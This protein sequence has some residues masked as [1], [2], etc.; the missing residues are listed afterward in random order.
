[1]LCKNCQDLDI[2]RN[3]FE[4]LYGKKVVE[5]CMQRLELLIVHHQQARPAH[6]KTWDQNDVMLITYGDMVRR[7]NQPPLRSLHEFLC[8]SMTDAI[9]A[10]HI[11]P[12]FPFSSDDGFS[13]IDYREVNPELGDWDDIKDLAKDFNLMF[14]LVLNHVSRSSEWF[15]EYVNGVLPF[16]SYFIE[17]DPD[18]D[19]SCVARPRNLPLL[20]P[21][22][23]REGLRY[24]WTTFSSDQIDLDFSNPDVLFDF[25][26]IMLHYAERGARFIRL[27]AIAYLW[28][29]IGTPCIH[30]PQTHEVVK[31]MRNIMDLVGNN[32]V[33]LTETNVPHNENIS[34]FG[35][36]DEAHMVYQFT[37]PP[38]LLNT[39]VTG[40]AEK[41]TDWAA[42]LQPPPHGCTF[43]NF[44]A[45]HDGI[46]VRPLE[47]ILEPSEIANLANIVQNR[48]GH[49]S[50]KTN[51]D[52]TESPYELNITY[53]SA[54]ADPDAHDRELDIARFICSQ[55]IPLE[56]RGIPGVYFNNL[57]AAI[58]D[59]KAVAER[60]TP[61]A[62]NRQKWPRE[63]LDA[64]ASDEH[65]IHGQVFRTYIDLLEERRKHPA[66]HPE[67]TQTI[68]EVNPRLFAVLRT[69]QNPPQT[70]LAL[71]NVTDHPLHIPR[72]ILSDALPAQPLFDLLAH[73]PIQDSSTIE[74]KPYQCRWLTPK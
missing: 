29:E 25:M 42:N 8:E 40:N 49:V 34:Y 4:R 48:G 21:T 71:N 16:K 31:L 68:L 27:D 63:Q 74:L 43:F 35:H 67:A 66:F 46:G 6:A 41:L 20:T 62:I 28:K 10:V 22:R 65:S 55:T 72:S 32:L 53:F 9:N 18:A 3:R 50:T 36:G 38:L 52:G 51:P 45:S 69:S 33:I 19:L 23:T 1:M 39:L 37:L 57:F 12:F 60:G 24:L 54:L 26:E 30:L 44:T 14:D 7:E 61:R 64:F 17:T 47:G 11:L 13:I 59:E 73:S 58:N 5:R 56:L 70:I 2:I 15:T